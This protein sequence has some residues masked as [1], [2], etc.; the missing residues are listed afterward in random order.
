MRIELSIQHILLSCFILFTV[1]ALG[2]NALS[3]KLNGRVYGT[4]GDVAATH[5]LNTTMRNATITDSDGFF[6]I[7][8]KLNDTIVLSAVQFKRKEIVITPEIIESKFLGIPLEEALVELD[9][10]VVTPYSLSGNMAKDLSTLS[11]E[12]VITASTLGF[13][14]AYTKKISKAER[15]LYAATSGGGIPLNPILNGISGR[16]NMLKNRIKRNET[17]ARTERVR[18]FY[19][20]SLYTEEL[21]IP[22]D[23]IDDFLYFC[24]VD[25]TFQST[26]DTHDRLSIWEYMRKKSVAY[27]DHIK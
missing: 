23:K 15:E 18:Q 21:K 17:Y 9:E 6:S 11:I 16:T 4:D 7:S 20:D 14:N 10:V 26:V 24:E 3:N 8:V 5:V 22:K 12:P 19:A 13:P 27:L 2:Q 1:S 25:A